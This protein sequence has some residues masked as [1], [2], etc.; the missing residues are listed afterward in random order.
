MSSKSLKPLPKGENMREKL[1]S[2]FDAPHLDEDARG[3][4]LSTLAQTPAYELAA[5]L[6]R[7]S[8]MLDGFIQAAEKVDLSLY[9]I[10]S[11]ADSKAR[12]MLARLE[13]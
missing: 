3:S 4:L 12:A 8:H 1:A 6:R 7:T 10:L 5:Q 9:C 11:E 2:L 13:A